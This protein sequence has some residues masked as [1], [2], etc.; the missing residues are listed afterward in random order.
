MAQKG[1]P[2]E[3]LLAAKVLNVS[4]FFC[5]PLPYRHSVILHELGIAK[6]HHDISNVFTEPRAGLRWRHPPINQL[7]SQSAEIA[8]AGTFLSLGH[9]LKLPTPP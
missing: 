6:V 7:P 1:S 5:E 4:A 2:S 3:T 9:C 8:Q